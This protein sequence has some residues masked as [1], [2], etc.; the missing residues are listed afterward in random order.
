[1]EHYVLGNLHTFSLANYVLV[2]VTEHGVHITTPIT[3]QP[4]HQPLH[5][6]FMFLLIIWFELP[7]KVLEYSIMWKRT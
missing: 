7:M 5:A 4:Q 3:N 2:L 1:M 6:L